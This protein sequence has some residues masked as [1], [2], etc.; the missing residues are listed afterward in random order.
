MEVTMV[1]SQHTMKQ[2]KIDLANTQEYHWAHI[3]GQLATIEGRA[4]MLAIEN[5]KSL[6][7][8]TRGRGYT[9]R[10]DQYFAQKMVGAL[11]PEQPALHALRPISPEDYYSAREPSEFEYESEGSEGSGTDS[12]G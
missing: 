6:V 12:A 11:A 9:R 4:W 10:A 8:Q 1:A 3:L 5:A 7:P 2:S